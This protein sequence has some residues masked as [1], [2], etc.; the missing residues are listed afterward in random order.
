M[1]HSPGPDLEGLFTGGE[2]VVPRLPVGRAASSDAGGKPPMN[3]MQRALCS[4][5]IAN[6][7]NVTVGSVIAEL[8]RQGHDVPAQDVR[9]MLKHRQKKQK[10]QGP[11]QNV[12]A[13][14][15]FMQ[16]RNNWQSGE[17]YVAYLEASSKHF[18]WVGLV[19][20]FFKALVPLCESGSSLPLGFF[21]A[22]FFVPDRNFSCFRIYDI[23]LVGLPGVQLASI[24]H[25][26]A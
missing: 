19:V 21:Y 6:G 13:A 24:M 20:P 8:M 9:Q 26:T 3:E 4:S 2:V 10:K 23:H 11:L 25:L 12:A 22:N 7:S 15:S 17:L 1:V 14:Q 18:A 16:E 5:I